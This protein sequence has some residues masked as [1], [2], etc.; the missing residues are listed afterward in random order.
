MIRLADTLVIST[1]TN[2]SLAREWGEHDIAKY[3]KVLA[4]QETGM[5]KE[6]LAFAKNLGY[7]YD[8]VLMIGDALGDMKAA[9]ANNVL[10]YP[11]N[12]GY[13]DASWQRFYEEAFDK[14][15]N[16]E[17][18]GDYEAKLIVEFEKYLPE[19]PSWKISK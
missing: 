17:Y 19:I 11:I 13:E 6:T 10:Y 3:V 18:A 12:P 16:C 15:I 1:T 14:F 2:A 5:K 8:H 9:K 4:G 7:A